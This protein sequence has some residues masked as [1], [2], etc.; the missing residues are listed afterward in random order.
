MVKRVLASAALLVGLVFPATAPATPLSPFIDLQEK[1]LT[2]AD[3]AVGLEGLGSG[4]R[5]FS[6]KVG[7]PVRFAL[8]YWAGRDL[9]CPLGPG[10]CT[11][12]QPYKDQQM[13]FNS[14][15]LTGTVIGTEQQLATESGAVNNIGYFADV[16]SIVSAAGPGLRS[17]TIADGNLGSNLF[18]LDGASLVVAYTDPASTV[19]YRVMVFDNLDFAFGNDLVPGGTRETSPVA[20][21]H[22]A[23]PFARTGALTIIAGDA[24]A[25][26][27]DRITVSGQPD[28]VGCLDGSSGARWDADTIP[29][30]LPP[31]TS[32]TTSRVFSDPG[33]SPDS[34]LWTMAMLRVPIDAPSAAAGDDCL[35]PSSPPSAE[36]SSSPAP[37]PAPVLSA[38]RVNP[39]AFAPPSEG[40]TTSAAQARIRY[41]SSETA[42][43]AFRVERALKGVRTDG[44]CVK[45]KGTGKA[46]GCTRF[47]PLRGGFSHQGQAGVNSVPFGGRLG[48]RVLPVGRYRLL[49]VASD[50]GGNN[51][52]TA[53]TR[54]RIKPVADR[55][56]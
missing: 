27:G 38:L 26:G 28:I 47:V 44:S 15:P 5:T 24:T 22:G 32:S 25:A 55:R 56:R 21:N 9:P 20:F 16:T 29:V 23:A 11:L 18:R 48:K 52:A 46:K 35:P 40:A 45:G 49:A 36:P 19:S 14:T 10:G 39:R 53:G 51:S 2:M 13:V 4:A 7:G 41:S 34:L 43:V 12:V 1:G 6:V 17:F 42:T 33:P 50:A 54:F 3:D 37:D 31:G 30:S 8:L